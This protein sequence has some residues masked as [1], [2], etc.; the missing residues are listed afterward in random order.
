MHSSREIR[1]AADYFREQHW[2][3]GTIPVD[4]ELVLERMGIDIVPIANL[5]H[6]VGMD[7]CISADLTC[8][9]LDLEYYCNDRMAFRVRFNQAH[10]LGHIVLH[11]HVFD[12]HEQTKPESVL[13]WARRVRGRFDNEMLEREADEF[14]SCLLVPEPDLRGLYEEHYPKI[15]EAF[16]ERG[17]DPDSVDPDILRGY[18]AQPIH[19]TFQVSAKTIEVRLRKYGI[20]P[21]HE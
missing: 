16:R 4:I 17:W 7:A 21:N 1:E 2:P 5:R 8:V 11:K 3:D 12:E 19:R 15:C 10:E 6:E 9:Y 20:C 14:A 13:D 18:L